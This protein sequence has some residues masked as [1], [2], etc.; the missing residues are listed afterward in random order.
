MEGKS[1]PVVYYD[2]FAKMFVTE[3]D[4]QAYPGMYI[5]IDAEQAKKIEDSQRRQHDFSDSDYSPDD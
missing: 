5:E 3:K 4:P 1:Y 2:R